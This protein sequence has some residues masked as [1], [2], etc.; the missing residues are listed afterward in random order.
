MVDDSQADLHLLQTVLEDFERN[1]IFTGIQ[2]GGKALEYLQDAQNALHPWP[3]LILIDL[4][5]PGMNGF[6]FIEQVKAVPQ[7]R[8]IPLVV[9]S[10]SAREEDRH[11]A[12]QLGANAYLQKPT[13]IQGLVH[14]VRRLVRFWQMNDQPYDPALGAPTQT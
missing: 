6:E 5:M 14:L 12:S 13:D 4:N 9:F 11:R 3:S 1:V 7:W 8:H 2:K 10:T